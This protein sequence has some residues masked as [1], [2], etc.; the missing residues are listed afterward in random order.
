[1][2]D[3]ISRQAAIDAIW[4]PIIKPNEM[5]FDALKQA[6]QNEIETIPSVEPERKRGEWEW[7]QRTGE[8]ECSECGCNPI[9]ERTTPDCSEIDKYKFCRWCGAVMEV[10]DDNISDC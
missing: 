8:Y 3:L 9:Y 7:D 6:Q 5:I 10:K 4:K 1:M 2:S